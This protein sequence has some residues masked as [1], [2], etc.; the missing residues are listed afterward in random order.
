[1]VQK[2]LDP[3]RVGGYGLGDEPEVRLG[4]FMPG[5]VLDI[6]S[7]VGGAYR[8]QRE[9]YLDYLVQVLPP[10]KVAQILSIVVGLHCGSHYVGVGPQHKQ[11]TGC[12]EEQLH[13]FQHLDDL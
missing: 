2:R 4:L 6:P 1:M 9:L 11:A 5:D 7:H 3:S 8:R 10:V 13:R 12:V